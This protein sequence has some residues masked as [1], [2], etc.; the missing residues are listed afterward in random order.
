[1]FLLLHLPVQFIRPCL[2][3]VLRLRGPSSNS[4]LGL[5]PR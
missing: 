1:M 3:L 5:P 2:R 4:F